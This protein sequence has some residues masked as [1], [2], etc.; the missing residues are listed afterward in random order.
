[1]TVDDGHSNGVT[2]P[3][4]GLMESKSVGQAMGIVTGYIHA[5]PDQIKD[6]RDQT[7]QDNVYH[8]SGRRQSNG[9]VVTNPHVLK[10]KSVS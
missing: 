3:N 2:V 1:L 4:I 6:A 8:F 5:F 10:T 7:V 9:V